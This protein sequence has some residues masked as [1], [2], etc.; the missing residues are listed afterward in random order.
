MRPGIEYVTA[1]SAENFKRLLFT[2][3]KILVMDK[4]KM[5]IECDKNS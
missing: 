2:E 5:A 3:M 1:I 4:I